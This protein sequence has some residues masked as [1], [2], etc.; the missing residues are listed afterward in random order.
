MKTLMV[1]ALVMVAG[2]NNGA[3]IVK[4]PQ[5]SVSF[6]SPKS[7]V[8]STST[9]LVNGVQID[10]PKD[11]TCIVQDNGEMIMTTDGISFT[12]GADYIEIH[13]KKSGINCTAAA[14]PS[15][16]S[17]GD[18]TFDAQCGDWRIIGASYWRL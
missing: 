12:V 10:G 5:C 13:D 14:K 6:A 9:A 15:Y 11:G 1:T 8:D 18:W 4:Q 2:C 17:S 7:L 3:L 16:Y